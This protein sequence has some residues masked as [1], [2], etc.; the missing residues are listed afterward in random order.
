MGKHKLHLHSMIV[1]VVAALA[2][3]AATAYIFYIFQVEFLSFAQHTWSFLVYFSLVVILF[4][5]IPTILSGVFERNHVYAKWHS[6]HK[7]KLLLSILLVLAVIIELSIFF[8]SG[9]GDNLFSFIGIMTI[10]ANNLI[11]FFLGVYGL[12]ISLGRQSFGKT[13]YTPDLFK[14]EPIDIL[15][16]AGEQRKKEAKYLDLLTER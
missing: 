9:M 6:T 8:K 14:K 10:L 12:K 11:M 5:S 1:H 13:S 15:I 2:P 16:N 4:I 3:L 7:I